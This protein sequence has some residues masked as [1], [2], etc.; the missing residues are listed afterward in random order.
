MEQHRPAARAAAI[1]RRTR[2][3]Q[4]RPHPS[5]VDVDLVVAIHVGGDGDGD[6]L[7]EALVREGEAEEHATLAPRST[8]ME[9]EGA[10]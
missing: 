2:I 6:D 10:T 8:G 1:T 5:H 3:T 4:I 9:G 7:R